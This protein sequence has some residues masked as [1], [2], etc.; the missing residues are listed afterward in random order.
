[1]QNITLTVNTQRTLH[2][3]NK[4]KKSSVL[5]KKQPAEQQ[6]DQTTK[7]LNNEFT[8]AT[9][10]AAPTDWCCT[11]SARTDG[12]VIDENT[13]VSIVADKPASADRKEGA[14]A[15]KFRLIVKSLNTTVPTVPRTKLYAEPS[16]LETDEFTICTYPEPTK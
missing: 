7:P 5:T 9:L 11:I 6:A 12:V 2:L 8:I 3:I 14:P 16:S 15:V 10:T 13:Q 4:K 1:M